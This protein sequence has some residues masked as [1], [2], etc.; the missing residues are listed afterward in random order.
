[1][2]FEESE[3]LELKRS[4]SEME[5]T[6][7]SIVAILNKLG[8][9]Q[10]G[11]LLNPAAILFGKEPSRFFPNAKLRCAVFART[12]TAYIIDRQEYTG[13]LV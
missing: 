2:Q 12:D 11:R 8:L 3:I 4:T 9:I 13:G 7:I 5:E 1:M 10:D 6:F